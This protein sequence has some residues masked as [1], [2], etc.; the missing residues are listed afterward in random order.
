M[1]H[2]PS[3]KGFS[4]HKGKMGAW[5]ACQQKGKGPTAQRTEVT[6]FK[7]VL[8]RKAK[9]GQDRCGWHA[10]KVMTHSTLARHALLNSDAAQFLGQV[11]ATAR[12]TARRGAHPMTVTWSCRRGSSPKATG[13]VPSQKPSSSTVSMAAHDNTAVSSAQPQACLAGVGPSRVGHTGV[14]AVQAHLCRTRCRP[15]APARRT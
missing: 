4:K 9:H 1:E 13:V 14:T 5:A 8:L 7:R 12:V 15:P 11:G 10:G 2:Q 3:G 6:A